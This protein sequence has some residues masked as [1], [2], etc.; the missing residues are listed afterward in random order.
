MIGRS[1]VPDGAGMFDGMFRTAFYGPTVDKIGN[2]IV[3][4]D[5]YAIQRF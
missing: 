4:V 3:A 1:K 2:G 5:R